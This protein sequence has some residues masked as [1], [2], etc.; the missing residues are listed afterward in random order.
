MRHVI[1][2]VIR[3]GVMLEKNPDEFVDCIWAYQGIVSANTKDMRGFKRGCRLVEPSEY[4]VLGTPE[5]LSINVSKM[6]FQLI[7]GF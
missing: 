5:N 6:I 3:S 7:V 2:G 4:V 1:V